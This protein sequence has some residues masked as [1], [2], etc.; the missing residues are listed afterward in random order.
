MWQASAPCS[1]R[2]A[3]PSWPSA[4]RPAWPSPPPSTASPTVYGPLPGSSSRR[5]SSTRSPSRPASSTSSAHRSSPS[6][7]TSACRCCWSVFRL[8]P[9]WKAPQAL[10]RRWPSPPRCW[11]A[12]ASTRSTPPVCASSPTPPRWPLAPWASPSWWLARFP[13]WIPTTSVRW[14]VASCPSSPSSCPSGWWP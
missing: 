5:Y 1:S 10:A 3:W 7:K 6:R 9:S 8:V 12:W 2:W 11:W 13:G 14:P 4:C